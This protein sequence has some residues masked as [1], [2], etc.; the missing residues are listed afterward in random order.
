MSCSGKRRITSPFVKKVCKDLDIHRSTFY[1]HLRWLCE[2]DWIHKSG[3]SDLFFII[4][5]S[6]LLKQKNLKGNTAAYFRA[7]WFRS[8]KAFC[9]GCVIG[10]LCKHQKKAG[11]KNGRPNKPSTVATKAL[12]KVLH[13][14]MSTAYNLKQIAHSNNY[15]TKRF[16]YRDTHIHKKNKGWFKKAFSEIAHKVVEYNGRLVVCL[17]DICEGNLRYNTKR[18]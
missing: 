4:S 9:S 11:R 12:A 8:F 13:I 15:I 10:Y 3:R 5:H 1:R 16:N 7:G 18:Y 6:R 2:H 17:P 14:P